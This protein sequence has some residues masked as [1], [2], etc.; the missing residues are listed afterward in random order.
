[1]APAWARYTLAVL[2]IGVWI[3]TIV[4][5]A[6]DPVLLPLTFTAGPLALV[7]CG[8]I[9]GREAFKLLKNGEKERDES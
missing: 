1:M 3:A 2:L 6:R 9:L 4:L 5:A 8:V 7:A